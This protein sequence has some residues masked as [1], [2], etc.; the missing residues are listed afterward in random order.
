MVTAET[1]RV[2]REDD[3]G[4]RFLVAAGL[5]REEAE[6]QVAELTAHGHKQVYWCEASRRVE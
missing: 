4:N 2:L 6:A 1:W 3:N 5:T